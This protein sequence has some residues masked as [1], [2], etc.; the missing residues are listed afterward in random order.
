MEIYNCNTKQILQW[1]F[2]LKY[3]KIIFFQILFLFL[4]LIHQNYPKTSKNINLIFLNKK[5][6]CN[7]KTNN[8]NQ[9][10]N[11]QYFIA[12]DRS[13]S[14]LKL[15]F[16]HLDCPSIFPSYEESWELYSPMT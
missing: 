9:V 4:I 8:P 13:K 12:H 7:I 3:I 5:I 16:F 2:I 1:F 11:T 10:R 6:N 14:K 15:H